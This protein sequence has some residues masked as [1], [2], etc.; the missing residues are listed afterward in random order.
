MFNW[1]FW[2]FCVIV[3]IDGRL[4]ISSYSGVVIVVVVYYN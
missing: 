1:F 4:F 3:K 2:L